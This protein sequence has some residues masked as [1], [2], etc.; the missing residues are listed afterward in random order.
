[1]VFA[2]QLCAWLG[3]V[4]FNQA[5]EVVPGLCAFFELWKFVVT[6]LG[7]FICWGHSENVVRGTIWIDVSCPKLVCFLQLKMWLQLLVIWPVLQSLVVHSLYLI[8]SVRRVVPHVIAPQHMDLFGETA[9]GIPQLRQTGEAS[10]FMTIAI[11]KR[12]SF[13]LGALL[14]ISKGFNLLWFSPA[15][16]CI[17]F[18]ARLLNQSVQYMRSVLIPGEWRW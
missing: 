1:M 8:A 7:K 5:L 12:F 3:T 10:A 11:W 9:Y 16:Y 15:S 13:H 4:G 2:G 18:F 14:R 17:L 6:S